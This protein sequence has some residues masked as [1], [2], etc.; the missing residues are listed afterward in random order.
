MAHFRDNDEFALLL[1][2]LRRNDPDC[3]SVT[4]LNDPNSDNGAAAA[5]LGNVLAG[6]TCLEFLSMSLHSMNRCFS[7]LK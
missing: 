1:E 6:N 2:E 7:G 4:F 5:S 3:T